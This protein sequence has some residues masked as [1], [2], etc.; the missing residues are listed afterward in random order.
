MLVEGTLTKMKKYLALFILLVSFGSTA[1]M[2]G[3]EK[4]YA[5]LLLSENTDE[6]KLGAKALHN[7]LL[8]NTMLWDL[9]AY[10][11]SVIANKAGNAETEDTAAWLI[12][13]IGQSQQAQYRIIL[14]QLNNAEQNRKLTRYLT[15]AINKLEKT[16]QPS[17]D[18]TTFDINAVQA[19]LLADA[20]KAEATQTGFDS[21]QPGTELTAVLDVLGQPDGVGQYIRQ[22][23]RPFVGR[24]TFQ[25]LRLSYLN[26][27]SMEFNYEHDSW[28]LRTKAVQAATDISVVDQQYQ[29]LLS[30]L[31]SNDRVQVVTAAK[32]AISLRLSDTEALDQIGQHI[33]NERATKDR[34]QADALAW[35]S[36]VLAA[37]GNGRYK[38]LL[39]TLGE[40]G[41][42]AKIVKYALN[43]AEKLPADNNPFQPVTHSEE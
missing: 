20:D 29:D 18:V 14:E 7:D 37:S 23:N 40:H 43:G 36:K 13:A 11:L 17:F 34:H 16:T 31:L 28:R 3:K 5:R 21:I 22:F 6:I 32:E 39:A 19:A 9:A 30:R 27:G 12:K 10:Q 35:L 33:W 42:N 38:L 26:L 15:Q 25:N 1:T 8:A 41:A 4:I 2:Q 24:Q